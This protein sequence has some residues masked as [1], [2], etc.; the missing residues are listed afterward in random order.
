MTIASILIVIFHVIPTNYQKVDSSLFIKVHKAFV[1][2]TH[3]F[4]FDMLSF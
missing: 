4:F 3:D 1:L 2:L